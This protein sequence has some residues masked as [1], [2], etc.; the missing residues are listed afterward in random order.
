MQSSSSSPATVSACCS[1]SGKDDEGKEF[2]SINNRL[3]S[4]ISSKSLYASFCQSYVNDKSLVGINDEIPSR[5]PVSEMVNPDKERQM[6]LL[7]LLAQ[8]CSLQDVTPKTFTVHVLNL[9]ERGIIDKENFSYLFGLGLVNLNDLKDNLLP[10]IQYKNSS[11]KVPF[12]VNNYPLSLS[13][14]EREFIQIRLLNSGSFGNV[15]H[16]RYKLDGANYAIKKVVF[17]NVGFDTST[18]Q[19]IM[20]EVQCLAQCDH[21]NIVRYYSSWLE[22]S[23]VVGPN[24]NLQK[25]LPSVHWEEEVK[26]VENQLELFS[27]KNTECGNSQSDFDDCS[28]WSFDADQPSSNDEKLNFRNKSSPYQYSVCLYIQMQLCHPSTVADWIHHRNSLSKNFSPS[29]FTSA[30]NIFRQIVCGVDHF[31]SKG[32]VHRDL[33]PA[34]IFLD[35]NG[36]IKVGD[37]GLSKIMDVNKSSLSSSLLLKNSP[38]S[39]KENSSTFHT[40]GVGTVSYA[41]PEQISSHTYGT[42]TDIFSLGLILL[43]ILSR[44]QTAHER[45]MA[46]RD[47]RDHRRVGLPGIAKEVAD[48]LIAIIIT[49]TSF[50]PEQRPT[51]NSLLDH[52]NVFNTPNVSTVPLLDCKTA[53]VS[54]EVHSLKLQLESSNSE[55]EKQKQKLLE[56]DN[57]ISDLQKQ[58]LDLSIKKD[59]TCSSKSKNGN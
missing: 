41:A 47:C 45:A 53:T 40:I 54:N 38:K 4:Y 11:E 26:W 44:F 57:L 52:L 33:K 27:S 30:V 20:R 28:E 7:M 55:L 18:I 15:Y 43:E 37:F 34:N 59:L 19:Y 10:S 31:H 36:V 14:Y 29:L 1:S 3:S 25:K 35:E 13:R 23:W 21:I 5:S 32:I 48:D 22:P 58:I 42:K 39:D 46:F 9:L 8:V 56:K 49:C 2:S 50:D 24:P 51:A 17:P 12:S 16:A 6:L